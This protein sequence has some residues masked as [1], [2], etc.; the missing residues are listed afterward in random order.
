MNKQICIYSLVLGPGS[1]QI[2][3]RLVKLINSVTKFRR[4]IDKFH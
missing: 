2:R 1:A 4:G 3:I